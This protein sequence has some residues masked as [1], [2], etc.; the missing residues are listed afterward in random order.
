M[1]GLWALKI[2]E[3]E[4]LLDII[5]FVLQH[6]CLQSLSLEFVLQR[7]SPFTINHLN[8]EDT[9]ICKSQTCISF[10]ECVNEIA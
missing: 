6:K 10:L 8:V 1:L 3:S 7:Q 2:C 5:F 4:F 9:L